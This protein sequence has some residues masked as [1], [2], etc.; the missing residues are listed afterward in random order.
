M[1]P[2]ATLDMPSAIDVDEYEN[3]DEISPGNILQYI[4][5]MV[6]NFILHLLGINWL[7]GIFGLALNP[8][9]TLDSEE[10]RKKLEE[11]KRKFDEME[12]QVAGESR[13]VVHSKRTK[14]DDLELEE[15]SNAIT[16]SSDLEEAS[17]AEPSFVDT[18]MNMEEKLT[19]V[20]KTKAISDFQKR[21]WKLTP[22]FS[23]EVE[24]NQSGLG[25]FDLEDNFDSPIL[26]DD[27]ADFGIVD[28]V[29]RKKDMLK[30]NTPTESFDD[31]S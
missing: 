22:D 17:N 5:C 6:V 15:A 30:V 13:N 26:K 23:F 1:D 8:L 9:D 31:V 28:H 4:I 12:Q 7:L 11:K 16:G 27:T 29:T 19:I 25:V 3:D 20:E 18:N 21:L 14:I 10:R 2:P 24:G